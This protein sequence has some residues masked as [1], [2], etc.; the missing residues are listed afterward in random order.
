[1]SAKNRNET[2]RDEEAAPPEGRRWKKVSALETPYIMPPMPPPAGIAGAS[3]S[4]SAT[5]TSVVTMRLPMDAAFGRAERVNG[6]CII[7]QMDSTTVVPPN[8]WFSIDKF[9]NLIIR[10]FDEDQD[11]EA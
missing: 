9:G 8:T 5:T 11:K 3:S 6:P 1:M 4:G 10:A 2:C 7:E